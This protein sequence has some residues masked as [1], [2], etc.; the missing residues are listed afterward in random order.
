L[1][2]FIHKHYMNHDLILINNIST[3]LSKNIIDDC[4]S[5]DLRFIEI[6]KSN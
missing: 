6:H 1:G 2:N 4:N 3:D 5:K